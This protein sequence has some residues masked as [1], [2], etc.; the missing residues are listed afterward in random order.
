VDEVAAA[1]EQAAVNADFNSIIPASR[2]RPG[3]ALRY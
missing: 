2:R 1:L 3:E